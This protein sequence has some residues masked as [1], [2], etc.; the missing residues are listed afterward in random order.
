MFARTHICVCLQITSPNAYF[1]P[2]KTLKERLADGGA[3]IDDEVMAILNVPTCLTFDLEAS[4][5]GR[6]SSLNQLGAAAK[7]AVPLDPID[8]TRRSAQVHSERCQAMIAF[9]CAFI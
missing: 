9:A 2:V 1:M 5:P 3:F 4:L 7:R 8:E 6:E